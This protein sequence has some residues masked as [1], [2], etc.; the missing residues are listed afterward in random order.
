MQKNKTVGTEDGKFV[1]GRTKAEGG[2]LVITGSFCIM[3]AGRRL[4]VQDFEHYM[5][6]N[7]PVTIAVVAEPEGETHGT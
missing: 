5:K 4:L 2:D 3:H 6:S 1:I 7:W